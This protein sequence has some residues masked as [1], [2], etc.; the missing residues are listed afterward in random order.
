MQTTKLK[1]AAYARVSTDKDDQTNS[2]ASQRSYFA[3]YIKNRAGW[4]L[5]EV[6]YDEGISGTQT[7]RRDGFNRM[8]QDAMNGEI[9]LIVTKEVSRFARNTVDTLTYTRKLKDFGVGVIFAIDNIDTR[10]SD[11]ELRLTI[12]ASMAQEESRKTSERVR[13]GQKRRMEQGVVFGR[14]LLG[15]T[16]RNGALSINEDEAPIVRAVF[17]K[18]TNEGKG[19]TVIARELSEEGMRPK[20]NKVWSNVVIHR[21]VQNEKYAGDLCQKKTITPNYLT[22]AK[23]YNRGE[24][25]MVYIRDHHEPIIDRD[26]WDRTQVEVKRRT[27]TESQKK[28]Y[29]NRYWCS[30]KIVC[31]ECGKSFV[32]RVVQKKTCVHKSWRCY[33]TAN[34]GGLKKDMDGNSIGCANVSIN[35]RSLLSCMAYCI[36]LMQGNGEALKKEVLQEIAS[37]ERAEAKQNTSSNIQK[38]IENLEAKKRKAIDAMLD[39]L[40]SKEDFQKQTEWYDAELEQLQQQLAALST[41]G[42]IQSQQASDMQQYIKAIDEILT[43]D[44]NNETLYREALDHMAVHADKTLD[45][46]LKGVPMGIRLKIRTSGRLETYRTEVM[47]HSFIQP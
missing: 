31:A 4:K 18:Y 7:K 38:R 24:E 42:K 20:R 44:E 43:F 37:L 46:W 34:H 36:G 17:H 26:L 29:S 25:E 12:M 8:I 16:V 19:T 45:V 40:I 2:L 47:E 1:V 11:G 14:D 10:D 30:G 22:H 32:S 39:G 23:K 9:D 13:W 35:D 27:M 5:S 15:Y 21:M 6:Y 3:D 28:K 41:K 33:A